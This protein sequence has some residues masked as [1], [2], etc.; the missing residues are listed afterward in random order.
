MTVKGEV[1]FIVK[2]YR[3]HSDFPNGGRMSQYIDSMKIGDELMF[4]GPFGRCFYQGNG[5]WM[6][7]KKQV[8]K[9]KIGFLAGGTGITPIF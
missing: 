7:N 5:K 9:R 4:E 3:E 8:V 1:S 2:V 6:I